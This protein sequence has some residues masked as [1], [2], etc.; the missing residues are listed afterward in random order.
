MSHETEWAEGKS[1]CLYHADEEMHERCYWRRVGFVIF[2][3][4]ALAMVL[5][6]IIV[7][8]APAYRDRSPNGDIAG[9][10]LLTE[11]CTNAKVLEHLAARVPPQYHVKFRAA[12]L[13]WGGKD[14]ASCYIELDLVNQRGEEVKFVWSIDEEGAP[15]NPPY[16]IPRSLFR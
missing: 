11:P 7:N 2:L 9:L 10:R 16:G 8:A 14:W 4:I 6:P 13:T 12:V 3:A 5:V 1:W 15:F